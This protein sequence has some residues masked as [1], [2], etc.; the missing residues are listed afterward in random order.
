VTRI[1]K[2]MA[3]LVVLF[4]GLLAVAA[5]A[6]ATAP[7]IPVTPGAYCTAVQHLAVRLGPAGRMYQCQNHDGWRWVPT[8]PCPSAS[9]SSSALPVLELDKNRKL[10]PICYPLIHSPLPSPSPSSSKSPSASASASPSGSAPASAA[11]SMS[12]VGV[13]GNTLPVTGSGSGKLAATGGALVAVGLAGIVVSRVR[14]RRVV[15]A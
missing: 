1:V 14:R 15:K 7:V 13:V 3:P 2:I 9:A 10:I 4:A 6:S 12:P 5:P 8:E 11:P